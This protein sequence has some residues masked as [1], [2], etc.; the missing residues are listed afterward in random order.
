MSQLSGRKILV[1]DDHQIIRAG[2]INSLLNEGCS[3][4]SQA[5]SFASARSQISQE[6]FSLILTD[7]HLGD[8][9]GVDLSQLAL[10]QNPLVT[11]VLF[12]F[13]ESWALIEKAR[14]CGFSLYLSKQSSLATIVHALHEAMNGQSTFAIFSPSL[15]RDSGM[16]TPLTHSELEVL[17]LM[18]QGMT[19]RE[20]A[21][22]RFNSE[23]TIKSHTSAIL[24]KLQSRNRVEAIKK[25][26]EL[27]LISL[28]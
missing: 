19:S 28:T 12:S 11:L 5:D 10:Q 23:A 20:I 26:R 15:P 9:D 4:I 18:S 24:R 8:G 21:E 6:S 25:G 27:H 7:Q 13:E 14:N 17:E 1:V 16:I 2:L 3:D 22:K